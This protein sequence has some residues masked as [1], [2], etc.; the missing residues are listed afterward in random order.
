[1]SGPYPLK[2]HHGFAD[3]PFVESEVFDFIGR[4]SFP[5]VGAKAALSQDEVRVVIAG[6]LRSERDDDRVVKQVQAFAEHA[7][8]DAVFL[9]LVVVFEQTPLLSEIA[10]ENALWARL[11][12]LHDIDARTHRWDPRVSSDARAPDFSMSFGGRGF[13]VIGLHPG[14]SRAARRFTRAALVFNLHSQ[15]EVLRQDGRYAK[16]QDVITARD[17]ALCGS[18]NPML[19]TH[20]VTSEAP[21][22]SG[23]AVGNDWGCPFRA[24]RDCPL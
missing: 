10:F 16:L 9:S 17:I 15:F 18:R 19:S 23:R 4:D 21:Q 2:T 6:D 12:A 3:R 8:N 1:M 13:Y 24:H 7:S 22:Y 20:G 14:A 11:Q 5:C